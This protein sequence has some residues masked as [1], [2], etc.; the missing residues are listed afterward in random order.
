MATLSDIEWTEATWNPLTG[1]NKISSGCKNCYAEKLAYRL[2]KMGQR[3][4]RNGFNLTLHDH[5][6]E[7]PLNWEY[8]KNKG[9]FLLNGEVSNGSEQF[10]INGNNEKMVRE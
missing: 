5:A 9:A 2:Q 8:R 1:C 10:G 7:I 3:N 4:Y 6:L